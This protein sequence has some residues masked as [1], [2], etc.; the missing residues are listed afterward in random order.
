MNL[1][2]KQIEQLKQRM[3]EAAALPAHDPLR[4]EVSREV[5]AAGETMERLWLEMVAED[6]RLR[7]ELLHVQPPVGLQQRLRQL[8]EGETTT[9]FPGPIGLATFARAAAVAALVALGAWALL[10]PDAFVRRGGP[11][12]VNSDPPSSEKTVRRIQTLGQATLDHVAHHH[13]RHPNI[14]KKVS[15]NAEALQR[16]LNAAVDF[17]VRIPNLG[18]DYRLLGANLCRIEGV[19]AVCTHW[20][21]NGQRYTLVQFR[22]DQCDLPAVFKKQLVTP[23]D[24]RPY[25]PDALPQAIFWSED[26]IA[27]ALVPETAL[28][29]R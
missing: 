25:R 21:K 11:I 3:S 12:S 10:G 8:P 23:D 18:K 15:G 6:E 4:L 7:L 20:V 16:D 28:A 17:E 19:E 14:L 2:E 27:Y 24:T 5:V 26:S 22:R 29:S 1:N 9:G 13:V